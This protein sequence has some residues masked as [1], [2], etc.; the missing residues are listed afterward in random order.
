MVLT[1]LVKLGK[2]NLQTN[3]RLTSCLF[4]KCVRIG[5]QIHS[6]PGR[7]VS[8]MA[9]LSVSFVAARKKLK[10]ARLPLL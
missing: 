2:L 7:I 10:K 1:M 8:S 3:G 6:V 5:T 9:R 4:R